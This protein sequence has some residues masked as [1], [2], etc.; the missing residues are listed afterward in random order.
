MLTVTPQNTAISP[1]EQTETWRSQFFAQGHKTCI[2]TQAHSPPNSSSVTQYKP[3]KDWKWHCR[4]LMQTHLSPCCAHSRTTYPSLLCSKVWPC[5]WLPVSGMWVEVRQSP[6]PSPAPSGPAHLSYT[7]FH[8]LSLP[9]SVQQLTSRLSEM[10]EPQN[11][12]C[13][14]PWITTWKVPTEHWHYWIH[15]QDR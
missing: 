13:L 3:P 7:I 4:V 12:R 9:V 1:A 5:E 6:P 11:T 14:G 8:S 2:Q 10:E 15:K